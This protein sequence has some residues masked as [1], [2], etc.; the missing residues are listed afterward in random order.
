MVLCA[1]EKSQMQ[2]L[3]RKQPTLPM[4]LGYVEG[5]TQ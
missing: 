4:G 2:A 3:D 1:D 5:Y